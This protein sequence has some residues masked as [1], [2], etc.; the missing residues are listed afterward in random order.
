[1]NRSPLQPVT[2]EQIETYRR[3]GVVLIRNMLDAEWIRVMQAAIAEVTARPEQYGLL[4]PSHGAMTSVCFMARDAWAMSTCLAM[5]A[6]IPVP[7][8]PPEISTVT[9]S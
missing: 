7:L 8:P 9:Q 5:K 4:G 1:M 2:T 6:V 3:D